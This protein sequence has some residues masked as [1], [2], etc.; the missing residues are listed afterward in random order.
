MKLFMSTTGVKPASPEA[1]ITTGNGGATARMYMGP[2]SAGPNAIFDRVLVDDV[3]IGSISDTVSSNTPPVISDIIDRSTPEDTST[4]AIAFTV[5][6]AESAA[7]SLVVSGSSSNPTQNL[8][9]KT[10]MV[11]GVAPSSRT[12]CSSRRAVSR[13]CG[14]GKP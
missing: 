10:A 6:D 14:R 11:A 12:I 4:G 1:N 2:T 8:P 7:S 5:G 3:P 13:F 9:S